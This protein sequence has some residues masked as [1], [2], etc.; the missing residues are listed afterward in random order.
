MLAIKTAISID[1]DLFDEAEDV[2][3]K[4]KVPRSKLYSIAMKD[5]LEHRKNKELLDQLNAAYS[6]EPTAEEQTLR[7][8]SRQQHKRIMEREW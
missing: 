8:V 4:M 2:A 5:F 6:T 3:K 1:K 7:R